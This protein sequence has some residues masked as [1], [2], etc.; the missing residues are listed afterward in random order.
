MGVIDAWLRQ[1][2]D[3]PRKQRH[4]AKRIWERLRDEYGCPLSASH[5]RRLVRERQAL[6]EPAASKVLLELVWAPGEAAQF[7]WGEATVVL[8]GK[9]TRIYLFM[10]RLS[11]APFIM[12]FLH[13]RME[14]FLEGH[15]R[16]FAFFG[17]VPR[18]MIYDN[19]ASA[20]KRVLMGHRR[21]L[22]ASFQA[23]RAHYLFAATFANPAS[24]W[25]KG[26]VENLVGYGRRTFLV[27][28]PEV[29]NLE[30]LNAL[31][32]E[33]C[34][35]EREKVLPG[36]DGRSVGE[37]WDA[38]RE[39]LVSLPPVPYRAATEHT[40]LVSSS[41]TVSHLETRYSVPARLAGKTLTLYAFHDHVEICD[42]EAL[43]A[44]HPLGERGKPCLAI[45]HYL[46]VLL[47][48][49]G[50]VRNARVVADLGGSVTAYR[51]AFLAARPDAYRAF[52]DVLMLLRRHSREA[53]VE[54]IRQAHAERLFDPGAVARLVREAEG[55]VTVP[56]QVSGPTVDQPAPSV[57][58]AL[59]RRGV[60]A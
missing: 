25:E 30:E 16:A 3:A 21:E 26:L 40:V 36:R 22:T 48:K 12:A 6:L 27:P 14:C 38:E 47:A 55:G 33:R 54:G 45:E 9:P 46:D 13:E 49:P 58:D 52:V 34:R 42:R 2:L 31:F 44:R 57:Y 11:G 20:V 5:V 59:L 18:R 56:A 53:V 39:A 24:G 50:A 60:P 51:D 4:T 28:V 8:G 17:G 35:S 37:L 43:V 32:L 19:L 1:D 15:V 41:A 29:A 7:D 10:M 23:M